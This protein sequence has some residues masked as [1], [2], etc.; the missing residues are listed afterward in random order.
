MP[1]HRGESYA[2]KSNYRIKMLGTPYRLTIL[3]F[4]LACLL[5][6]CTSQEPQRE[7]GSSTMVFSVEPLSRSTLTGDDNIYS[8]PFAVYSDM[9]SLNPTDE[10]DYIAILNNTEVT[11]ESR[12]NQWTYENPQY[13]FPG[14]Q[15]AFVA[16]H[17]AKAQCIR[18]VEYKNNGMKLRYI[19]PS[20]YKSAPDLL[21]ATH[22]RDYFDGEAEPVSFTFSHILTNV[23]IL[24]TYKGSSS[25]PKSL[26]INE[27][28]FLNIPSEAIYGITPAPITGSSH[29]TSDWV[30]DEG[31]HMGWT[32]TKR[33]DLK[34]RFSEN[35]PRVVEANKGAF[36]LFS[37]SDVLL[38]LPDP[39]DPDEPVELEI[40]YTTE[41][42]DQ[43]TISTVIPRGWDP[44]TNLTLS[45]KMDNGAVQFSVSVEDW[46]AGI[47]SNTTVP[48]K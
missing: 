48:R 41:A 8:S 32:V 5:G 10:S 38:L 33:G 43:E 2:H 11:F 1:L 20:N 29:M 17:P 35:E 34:I 7:A 42:G 13:W 23:N 30:N 12:Y 16:H 46:K 25:G 19:Q 36:P 3:S 4:F 22:R 27:L 15:Y 37:D 18:S 26:K 39:A 28:N 9:M 31:S 47:S 6:A 44:A 14:F 21:I 24:F 45:L 40:V